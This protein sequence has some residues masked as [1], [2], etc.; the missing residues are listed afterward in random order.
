MVVKDRAAKQG[1]LQCFVVTTT[2]AKELLSTDVSRSLS[3]S[4]RL[5]RLPAWFLN[6][7]DAV[8]GSAEDA[9]DG[10]EREVDSGDSDYEGEDKGDSDD[11][12]WE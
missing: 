9:E 5:L 3:N 2:N 12:D 4:G 8:F 10:G 7:I 11:S 1:S 6:P